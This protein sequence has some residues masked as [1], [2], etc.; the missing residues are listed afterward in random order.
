M[1]ELDKK[2]YGLPVAA[3]VGVSA[4][5]GKVFANMNNLGIYPP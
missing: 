4:S 5:G 3:A 2:A 1:T